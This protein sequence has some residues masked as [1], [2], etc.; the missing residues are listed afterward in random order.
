MVSDKIYDLCLPV[1]DDTALE[2]E[3]K[4]DKLEELLSKETSLTGRALQ[5]AL[6]AILWRHRDKQLPPASPNLALR[7]PLARKS[8]ATPWQIP[9]AATPVGSPSTL[10]ASPARSHAFSPA[11]TRT[12][13]SSASPWTSPRPSPR[14]AFTQAIPHSPNLNQYEFSDPTIPQADY[15]DYGSDAV[16]WLVNDESPSRPTSSEAGS[17]Q[18]QG[19]SLSGAAAAWVQP[20][21]TDMSP[22]DMLRSILGESRSDEELETALEKNGYDLSS[23]ITS[24]MGNIGAF[25]GQSNANAT[26]GKI[27]VG[28]SMLPTQPISIASS[29]GQSSV[30]CKYWLQTGSCL[31]YEKTDL[32]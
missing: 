12:K 29:P 7:G 25:D 8:S 20:Q 4:T 18:G 15:G 30:V 9:R 19:S 3:E 28:K 11:F 14:L 1:L 5:D 31:R 24:L 2:E 16:D 17:T 13:S 22:Y 6:L 26:E 21:Q 27:V 10:A 32:F 23:T